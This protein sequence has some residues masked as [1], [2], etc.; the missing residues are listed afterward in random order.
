[1][2]IYKCMNYK[3]IAFSAIALALFVQVM[4][5]GAIIISLKDI[6]QYFNISISL[7]SWL[8]IIQLLTV[9]AVLIPAG[10]ISDRIGKKKFHIVG[11]IIFMLGT[12]G[13]YFSTSFT[14]LLIF[15][16]VMAIGSGMG[17]AVGGAI[18]ASLFSENERGKS[19][20]AMST[21]V[22]LGATAGPVFGGILVQNFGW[23]SVYL[24]LFIPMFIALFAGYF[25]LKDDSPSKNIKF[26]NF[27][28]IGTITGILFVVLIIFGIKN[29][30]ISNF[31]N[32][33]SMYCLFLG[34]IF[35]ILFIINEKIISN[36]LIN[37]NL[38][39]NL[40]FS[41][42]VSTRFFAFLAISG[43]M[44]MMPIFL[45][46]IMNINE[47]SVGLMLLFQ[48]LGMALAAS[49]GGR[50]SDKFGRK[51]FVILGLSSMIASYFF[52]SQLN[53]NSTNSY[54]VIL[55][56]ITGLGMGLWGSP[57]MAQ[58]YSTLQKNEYGFV[59][60]LI[61]FLRNIGNTLG[62]TYA[63]TI[64]AIFL[65]SA[66]Y[67]G[68]ISG[69][70]SLDQETYGVYFRAWQFI[71]LSSIVFLLIALIPNIFLKGKKTL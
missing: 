40:T 19:L 22:G 53:L 32:S 63:S 52:I 65:L 37:F 43:N 3:W 8:V 58:T 28:F 17:Q 38:L 16:V 10:K 20:G 64:L 41:I 56:L 13:G 12:L 6:A 49:I 25:L 26:E 50:L 42:A 35:G 30:D 70:G 18:V 67:L 68:D 47:S 60:S 39:N 71:Y 7:V 34:L 23:Q 69:L 11:I 55:L 31:I 54:I 62:Q 57:N 5:A 27:D 24:A 29:I 46:G 4:S 48:S 59:S 15:R 1:M 51:M 44:I 61:A 14:L 66:G 9:T 2:L 45:T 36:P 21:T 33:F